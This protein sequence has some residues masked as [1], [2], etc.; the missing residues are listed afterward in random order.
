GAAGFVA[1]HFRAHPATATTPTAVYGVGLVRP[2]G[3][4]G[5]TCTA[6][7][8]DVPGAHRCTRWTYVDA[9][10]HVVAPAK[11]PACRFT[12]VDQRTGRWTCRPVPEAG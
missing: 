4:A 5:L 1:L 10:Q 2:H 8:L 6:F 11:L 9:R 12:A 7:A 3:G